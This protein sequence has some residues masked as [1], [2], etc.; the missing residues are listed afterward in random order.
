MKARMW[1]TKV[2]SVLTRHKLIKMFIFNYTSLYYMYV[3]I[4]EFILGN[5]LA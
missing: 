3:S 4:P 1:S 2:M 5:F